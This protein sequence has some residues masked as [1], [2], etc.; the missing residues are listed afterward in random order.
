MVQ[1]FDPLQSEPKLKKIKNNKD[2]YLCFQCEHAA[3]TA[4][5][6]KRH[7]ESKHEGVRYPCPECEYVAPSAQGLKRHLKKK[8]DR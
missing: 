7:I 2:E 5:H 6:L 3:T 4:R 1:G 8:H